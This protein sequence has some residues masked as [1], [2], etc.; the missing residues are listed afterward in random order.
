[1]PALPGGDRVE[2]AICKRAVLGAGDD[3]QRQIRRLDKHTCR[4]IE[5]DDLCALP[6]EAAG[7]GAGAAAKIQD[8]AREPDAIEEGRW[9]SCPVV[10]VVVCGLTEVHGMAP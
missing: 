10:L 3:P 7:E 5:R 1:M 9:E 2:G 6:H 8:P 4:D